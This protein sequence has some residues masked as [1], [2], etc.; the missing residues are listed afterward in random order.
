MLQLLKV[1][2]PIS[3]KG[4]IYSNDTSSPKKSC[5]Q[6]SVKFGYK[7]RLRILLFNCLYVNFNMVTITSHIFI[8]ILQRVH[9]SAIKFTRGNWWEKYELS[10]DTKFLK[11]LKKKSEAIGP[12]PLIQH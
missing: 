3:P 7:K 1:P 4:D 11:S 5:F 12:A 9:F 10:S 2:S 8:N 6:I